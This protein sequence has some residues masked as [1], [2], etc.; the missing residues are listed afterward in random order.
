VV[1]VLNAEAGDILQDLAPGRVPS[2]EFLNSLTKEQLDLFIETSLLADG[3]TRLASYERNLGQKNP[4]SADAFQYACILAGHATS[5]R[6]GNRLAGY[7]YGMTLVRIR[8]QR[9]FKL[10]KGRHAQVTYEGT[11]WCP[12]TASG[13]WLARRRGKVY[14]TGNS[15]WGGE[16]IAFM[17]AVDTM[18]AKHKTSN[19]GTFHVW[20]PVLSA[21]EPH[22][23][24]WEGQPGPRANDWLSERYANAFG[25]RSLMRQVIDQTG[26][27]GG[28]A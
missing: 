25:D 15:G 2:Y 20:H 16:D 1:A 26:P 10:A 3:H 23:R 14:F 5:V 22:L 27:A 9:K 13:T 17:R 6:T 4:Q 21:G 8:Q 24:M 12:T 28:A 11:V 19:N 7:D 18:Y